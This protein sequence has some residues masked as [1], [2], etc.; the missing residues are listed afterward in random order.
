MISVQGLT[1]F[2]GETCALLDL[3]FEVAAGEVLGLVGQNGAG[4]TTCLQCVAGILPPSEGAIRIAGIDLLADAVEAKR[5]L[6]F[7][8]DTAQLFDYLTVEEHLQFA[9]RV[10]GLADWRARAD[11][12]LEEL[13]LSDKRAALPDELSRGMRQKVAICLA[14]LHDPVALVCDEPLSGLDPVGIRVMREA[15]RRR[16]EAGAALIVSS[17][18]LDLIASLCDRVLIVHDGR[19]VLSGTLVQVRAAF[20]QL[21]PEADLEDLYLAAIGRAP[22]AGTDD[23]PG[24]AAD[25]G[26]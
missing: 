23:A 12:L 4:K 7:I 5:K 9:A 1:R 20:P 19:E 21:G 11:R 22:T 3:T 24:P 14:L 13:E 10:H 17:H 18:Q 8:P 6:A 25:A 2:Y 26:A 16:A 15:L